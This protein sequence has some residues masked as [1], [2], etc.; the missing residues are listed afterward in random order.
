MNIPNAA[1]RWRKSSYSN[2]G[3]AT[4]VE[5]SDSIPGLTPV[6]DSKTPDSPALV[7]TTAAWAS[8]LTT[9]K[10]GQFDN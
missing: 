6:R 2:G 9:T 4:C 3:D 7:F 10:S 8:F 1:M 5:V